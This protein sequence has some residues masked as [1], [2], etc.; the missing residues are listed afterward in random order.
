[1]LRVAA[2]AGLTALLALSLVFTLWSGIRIAR[3]PDLRPL[4]DRAGAEIVAATDRAMA[5]EATAERIAARLAALLAEDPRNW[6]AIDAVV[7]V[8]R[9][10]SLPFDEA[11]VQAAR[12]ADS[13]IW[14]GMLDCAA[15]AY[16]PAQCQLSAVLICQVP[17][18]LTSL[19]DIAGLTRGGIAYVAGEAVDTLEV[20]LSAVGLGATVLILASGGTTLGVKAGAGLVKT[21]HRMRLLSPR[22]TATLN[23]AA[24]RGLD[25]PALAAGDLRRA[26]RP[27]VLAPVTSVA[28]NVNR[29]ENV[30]PT[31]QTLHLLRYVD[32]GADARRIANGAEALGPRTVGRMEVLGKARFL[33]ATVRVSN[34]AL[35][36]AA[37]IIGLMLSLAG[38]MAHLGQSLALRG[39][40][41]LAR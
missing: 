36:L 17:V 26:L 10:R 4:T 41:R 7:D 27:D 1:M 21:A 14:S 30:L 29:M 34:V 8:A 32:D 25:W 31:A 33:R 38:M 15:C 37:G 20:A 19:G 39:L 16:D 9:E 24:T 28:R 3:D 2:R 35:G 5:R 13:G 40:R 18:A 6:I 22:L 12:A 23:R 11:A